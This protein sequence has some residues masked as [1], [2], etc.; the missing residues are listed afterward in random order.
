MDRNALY[1]IVSSPSKD[2]ARLTLKLSRMRSPDTDQPGD[3]PPR[4]HINS[5][6]ESDLK[7]QLSRT[8]ADP[9]PKLDAEEQGNCQQVPS[10]PN[11]K[12]SGVT[13]DESE[14][15]TLAEIERIDRELGGERE[16]WSKEVQDKGMVGTHF[17]PHIFVCLEFNV[18]YIFP[19]FWQI[20]H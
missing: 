4:P 18:S 6:H 11:A 19:L 8:A 13:L 16:R 12:D 3:L 10:R 20:N 5:D 2:S 9:S 7:N 14:M 1:G 17:S 15:E